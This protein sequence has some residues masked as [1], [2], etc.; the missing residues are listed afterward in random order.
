MPDQTQ[1]MQ[2]GS[3]RGTKASVV[4]HKVIDGG[5]SASGLS[6]ALDEWRTSVDAEKATF[7]TE[8]RAADYVVVVV[9]V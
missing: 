6:A 1:G 2:L 4:K 5:G 8:Y 7:L 3:A 9:Y